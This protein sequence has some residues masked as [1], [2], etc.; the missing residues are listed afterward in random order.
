MVR[1]CLLFATNTQVKLHIPTG[2]YRSRVLL[3]ESLIVL[4]EQ[5]LSSPGLEARVGAAQVLMSS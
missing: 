5:W 4:Q 1:T 2:T 3:H